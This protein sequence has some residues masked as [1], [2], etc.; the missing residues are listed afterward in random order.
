M[1]RNLSAYMS[2]FY[3][4]AHTKKKERLLATYSNQANRTTEQ[5]LLSDDLPPTPINLSFSQ[6]QYCVSVQ[7]DAD[8][9][10]FVKLKNILQI[11]EI[12]IFVS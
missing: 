12:N 8:T 4:H 6:A 2:Q 1:P 7:F 10:Q 3:T 11:Q 9:V 5:S